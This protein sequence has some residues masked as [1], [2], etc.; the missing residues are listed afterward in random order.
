M[1]ASEMLFKLFI[2]VHSVIYANW[3]RSTGGESEGQALHCVCST[4][5]RELLQV[6]LLRLVYTSERFVYTSG[7]RDWWGAKVLIVL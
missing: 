4:T 1:V 7:C 3:R 2:S 6:G 5:V